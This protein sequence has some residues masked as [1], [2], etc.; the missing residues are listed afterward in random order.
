MN[1]CS[2]TD[3]KLLH[4]GRLL[5]DTSLI[6]ETAREAGG[7]QEQAKGPAGLVL[8]GA[9]EHSLGPLQQFVGLSTHKQVILCRLVQEEWLV[10]LWVGCYSF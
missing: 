3:A 5:V 6:A 9:C 8:Q 4:S 2:Q 1:H 7:H 10:L